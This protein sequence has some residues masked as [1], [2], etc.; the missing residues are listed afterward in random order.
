MPVTDEKAPKDSDC[1]LLVQGVWDI[2]T[3][4]EELLSAKVVWGMVGRGQI[5]YGR[6][7]PVKECS[8]IVFNCQMGRGRTTTGMII[9]SMVLLRKY[10][11]TDHGVCGRGGL[12]GGLQMQ[13]AT[14]TPSTVC[15]TIVHAHVH[16]HTCTCMCTHTHTTIHNHIHII[17]IYIAPCTRPPIHQPH[18]PTHSCPPPLV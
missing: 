7:P 11:R 12:R 8:A 5:G 2:A 10:L 9:A 16:L 18:S 4:D 17:Y 6:A 1:D 15:I 3:R 13:H 14:A